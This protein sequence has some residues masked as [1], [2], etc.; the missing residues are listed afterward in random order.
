MKSSSTHVPLDPQ[1]LPEHGFA[2]HDNSDIENWRKIHVVSCAIH[3]NEK[4]KNIAF[5][6]NLIIPCVYFFLWGGEITVLCLHSGHAVPFSTDSR[7][8]TQ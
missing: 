5:L 1:G 8:V 4:Y 7:P 2:N 3:H 6:F